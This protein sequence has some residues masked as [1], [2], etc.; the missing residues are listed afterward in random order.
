[1]SLYIMEDDQNYGGQ[2]MASVVKSLKHYLHQNKLVEGREYR[3]YKSEAKF[4]EGYD[5][6]LY[7]ATNDKLKKSNGQPVPELNRLLC[8]ASERSRS[9]RG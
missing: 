6:T 1:M 9:M 4:R 7:T 5:F 3:V 2:R 8:E